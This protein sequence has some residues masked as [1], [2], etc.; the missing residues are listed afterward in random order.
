M[1]ATPLALIVEPVPSTLGAPSLVLTMNTA[2]PASAVSVVAVISTRW[3]F[4]ALVGAYAT[5]MPATVPVGL[6]VIVVGVPVGD[7][8]SVGVLVGL[9]DEVSVG[10]AVP[11][12][13]AV[14]VTVTVGLADPEPLEQPPSPG[15]PSRSRRRR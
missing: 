2:F 10:V 3:F 14:S 1:R 12:G 9:G 11:V 5:V 15:R 13:V 8:G 7:G 6:G 4:A